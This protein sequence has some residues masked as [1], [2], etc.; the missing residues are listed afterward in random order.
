MFLKALRNLRHTL[1][2][3]LTIWYATIFAASS[4]LSFALVYVLI[5]SFI[6]ERT[7]DDLEGDIEEFATFLK[8]GGLERVTKQMELDTHGGEAEN[9]FYRLWTPAGRLITSDLSGWQGLEDPREAIQELN[10]ND[11]PILETLTLPQHEHKIRTAIGKLGSGFVFQAGESLEDDDELIT[12]LLQ[13]FL[14]TLV[15][16]IVLGGPIGWFMARR[17]LRGV[18]EITRTATSIAH[19]EL[20]QRVAVRSAAMSWTRWRKRSTRCWIEFRR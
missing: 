18:Q 15:M 11:E 4:F 6:Q 19:G 8:L 20:D 3:R 13:G 17:A 5:V 12:R 14:I 1:A 7:D 9:T 2:L 10:Y 16:V